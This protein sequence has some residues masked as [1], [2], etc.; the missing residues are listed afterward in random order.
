MLDL[1]WKTS[2]TNKNKIC[3]HGFFFNKLE[4]IQVQNGKK[5]Y[6]APDQ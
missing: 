1:Y 6:E 2:K 5:I 3:F 4:N